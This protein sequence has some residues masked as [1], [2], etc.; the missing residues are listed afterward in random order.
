MRIHS[1][2]C[3]KSCGGI[4]AGLA[5]ALFSGSSLAQQQGADNPN[6]GNR[7]SG[8]RGNGNEQRPADQSYTQYSGREHGSLGVSLTDNGRGDVWVATVVPTSPADRAGLRPGDQIVGFDNHAI[9]SYRDAVHDINQKG[10]HD[11]L[12]VHVLRNGQAGTV[13][14]TLVPHQFFG[15]AGNGM[16]SQGNGP[17]YF[18]HPQGHMQTYV[19]PAPGYVGGNANHQ[20]TF[21]SNQQSGNSNQQANYDAQQNGGNNNQQNGRTYNPQNGGNNGQQN[22]GSNGQGFRRWVITQ[23]PLLDDTGNNAGIQPT[24]PSF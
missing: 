14:A 19:V 23:P 3:L 18:R 21:N 10:P 1:L 12:A 6:N 4:V 11:Q 13:T 15:P 20:A 7:D 16:A 9:H 22:R 8:N 17:G 2:R 24:G 5:L